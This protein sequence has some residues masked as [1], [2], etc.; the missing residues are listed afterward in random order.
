MEAKGRLALARLLEII[1]LK[2]QFGTAGNVI[3]AVDNVNLHVDRGEI[4]CVVGESGCGKTAMALSVMGLVQAGGGRCAGGRILFEGEDLLTKPAREMRALRGSALAMIYQEPMTAINPVFTIGSQIVEAILAHRRVNRRQ[5]AE[6][7]EHL[8]TLV[9]IPDAARRLEE[10]PHQLSGGMCQRAMIA[11]ALC[12]EPRLLIADE[13][14]TALDVTIQAQILDLIRRL[15]QEL[16]MA[17]L[18]ITHDLG[19]VAELADRVAVMYAGKVVEEAPAR[20]LFA[21]PRHPYTRGLLAC[22]PHPGSKSRLPAIEGMVPHPAHLP[23]G[24]R[25]R[26]RCPLAQEVCRGG[27]PE[28]A[29]RGGH[30][31]ACFLAPEREA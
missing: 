18:F 25:F 7:A 14:T 16:G 3:T 8:L 19:V 30:R 21:D 27:E 12:C 29:G 10:Y 1:N 23:G 26:T 15:Q 5:A 9:G 31:A 28:L 2:T 24:C 22:I 17:I 11:M 6:K 4:L 13:P 20:E